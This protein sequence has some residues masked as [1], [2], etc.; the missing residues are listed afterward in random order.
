MRT[1]RI[2]DDTG[3]NQSNFLGARLP[4]EAVESEA[5]QEQDQAWRDLR[6]KT[7]ERL[8]CKSSASATRVAT[9]PVVRFRTALPS[10]VTIE[11]W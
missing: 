3:A 7:P 1:S 6:S 10:S 4:L 9:L 2:R 5:V 8:Q 11:H